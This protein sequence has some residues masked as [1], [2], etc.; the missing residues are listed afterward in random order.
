MK[1]RMFVLSVITLS[2]AIGLAAQAQLIAPSQIVTLY[3]CETNQGFKQL[4]STDT[5]AKT[6]Y[7]V[8]AGHTLMVT[9]MSMAPQQNFGLPASGYFADTL[10]ILVK[11]TNYVPLLFFN[12]PTEL[13]AN[14]NLTLPV[15]VPSGVIFQHNFS[16]EGIIVRG[17]LTTAP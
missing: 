7:T 1:T 16:F 4:L 17:Y 12:M 6:I 14:M 15:P 2:W 11:K 13:S 10:S 9:A 5:L 8:P 3:S